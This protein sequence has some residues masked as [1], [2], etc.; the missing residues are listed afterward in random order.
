MA[1]DDHGLEVLKKAGEEVTPGDKSD[2]Y[3]KVGTD[4]GHPLDVNITDVTINGDS[5]ISGTVDGTATGTER[6]F[7]NNKRQQVL[8]SHDLS[9]SYTWLDFGTKKERVSTIVYTSSTFPSD[10]IT[11]TFSYTLVG[12]VYRLDT[13]IWTSSGGG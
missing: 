4:P 11:R 8:S 12:N 7:V 5:K 1:V 6:T 9:A 3:I 10:T 13:E 2:Y